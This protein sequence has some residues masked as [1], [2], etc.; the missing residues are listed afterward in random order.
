QI[1]ARGPMA[2]LTTP[3]AVD[4]WRLAHER[5]GRIPWA[6]LFSDAITYARDGMAVSRSLADWLAADAPILKQYA[7]AARIYLPGGKILREGERLV[8]ADL[9]RTLEQIATLGAREGFY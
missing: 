3:G 4:G 8:Q 5:H 1:P 6:E 7:D 9:A 2:V